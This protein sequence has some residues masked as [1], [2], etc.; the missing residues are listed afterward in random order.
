MQAKEPLQTLHR[1]CHPACAGRDSPP[2]ELLPLVSKEDE[3]GLQGLHNRVKDELRQGYYSG[4]FD[5]LQEPVV[6]P[7]CWRE[8]CLDIDVESHLRQDAIL[9][10]E[11]ILAKPH[12]IGNN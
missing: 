6:V 3:E 1:P 2:P 9:M 12:V 7:N 4:L 11:L 10:F 5:T 8:S